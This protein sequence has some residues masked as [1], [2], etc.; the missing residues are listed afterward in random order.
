MAHACA[1]SVPPTENPGISLGAVMGELARRGRDK[2]TFVMPAALAT[3]GMWLEQL[4]AESTGK[5]GTGLLPVVG[6]PLGP[7]AVYGTDRLFIHF[8]L[9]GA[10]DEEQLQSVNA[11]VAAGQPVVTILLEDLARPGRGIPPLGDR[12]GHGRRHSGDQCLRPA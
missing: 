10:D 5:D 9:H 6:E 4:L 3:F 7:P 2:V 1:S 12:R 8:R 11:L